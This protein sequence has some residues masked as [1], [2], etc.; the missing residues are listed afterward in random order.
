MRSP[1]SRSIV[2]TMFVRGHPGSLSSVPQ[3]C[4]QPLQPV[5][6]QGARKHEIQY[7]NSLNLDCFGCVFV[8]RRLANAELWKQFFERLLNVP[9]CRSL[10]SLGALRKELKD[11]FCKSYAKE[12]K[13]FRNRL[14]VLLI[15]NKRSR[16]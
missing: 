14:V 16:K 4:L 1:L 12:V 9:S 3:P 7:V 2:S 15:E 11:L 6:G 8:P 5:T 13:F 10:P